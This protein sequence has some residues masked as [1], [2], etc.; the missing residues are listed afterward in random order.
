MLISSITLNEKYH[1]TGSSPR[2]GRGAQVNP[3][4]K[5]LVEHTEVD[6]EFLEYCR[7]EEEEHESNSTEYIEVY[8]KRIVNKVPSPDVPMDYSM[9]PYQGCEHG[10]VYCYARPTHE[11]WG[12]SSGLDFERKIL[13]KKNAPELLRRELASRAWKPAPIMLSGNT[14]CYQPAEQKLKITRELLKTLLEFRNPVG[15][16][17]KNS[18]ILRDLDILSELNERNLLRVVIS[19]TSLTEDTRRILEPR[20]ASCKNRVKAV[21][22]LSDAGIPVSV[23]LAPIIPGINDHEI[24]KILKTVSEAG[25]RSA[26][27]IMVRLNG[28]IEGIFR[29]WVEA[30][31]PDRAEKVMNQIADLHGGKVADSRFKT[32]MRGEGHIAEQIRRLFLIHHKMYFS[33]YKPAKMDINQFRSIRKG[34]IPLF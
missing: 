23:N 26:N 29:N 33:P 24:P 2:K 10:C 4:N 25:A 30:N 6:P 11:Y 27:Y 15:I 32:R 3:K 20:T 5:F 16:I 12:Y 13:V 21:K 22:V 9:N 28:P 31:F 18:L 8:P 1:A 7:F 17:T 19:I 14:D 34:Q